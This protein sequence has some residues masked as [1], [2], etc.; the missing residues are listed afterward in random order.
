MVTGVW[1]VPEARSTERAALGDAKLRCCEDARPATASAPAPTTAALNSP[2]ARPQ[3][4]H[5]PG[6]PVLHPPAA[7]PAWEGFRM[8]LAPI[9]R[10]VGEASAARVRVVL[11]LPRSALLVPSIQFFL[12]LLRALPSSCSPAPSTSTK[13][14]AGGRVPARP[15]LH[16]SAGCD[17]PRAC[18]AQ[19]GSPRARRTDWPGR[20]R[21]AA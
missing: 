15:P 8:P 21:Q 13:N 10:R 9:E 11:V 12:P 6:R 2:C 17:T 4:L 16:G 5:V 18:S 14:S 7:V 19:L 1:P 3:M 20:T